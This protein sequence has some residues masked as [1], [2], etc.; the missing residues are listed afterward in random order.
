MARQDPVFTALNRGEVSTQLLGRTDIEHLRLAAQIQENWQPRVLG[1]MSLRPGSAM[2]GQPRAEPAKLVPFVAQFDDTAVIELTD[3]VM[4]VWVND[5]VVTRNSVA[6]V[7]PGFGSWTVARQTGTAQYAIGDSGL[8]IWGLNA[9]ASCAIR[10]AVSVGPDDIGREHGV[11]V[12]VANGPIIFRIGSSA[13]ADDLFPSETLDTGI[14]SLAFTPASG[15]VYVEL[16]SAIAPEAYST[17]RKSQP[18]G[19]YQVTVWSVAIESAGPMQLLTPWT[20]A[21]IQAPCKLRFASSAD[22]IFVAAPGTPQNQIVRYGVTSWSIVRYRPVKG[23]M[24]AT[25]GDKSIV[26]TIPPTSDGHTPVGNTVLDA[27]QPFFTPDDVGTLF[28]LYHWRQDFTQ[29]ITSGDTWTDAIRVSGVSVVSEIS[30]GSV[31]DVPTIDR[32]FGIVSTGTWSGTLMLQRSFDGYS[33]GFNDYKPFT[34]NIPSQ[35]VTDSLNNVIVYYRLGF[36]ADGFTSGSAT[37]TISYPGGGGEGIVHVTGY[38]SPTQVNVEILVPPSA[39][40][41]AFDWRQSQWSPKQGYPSAVAIHEGRLWW[42]GADRWWGSTSDDYSNFD[43]DQIGDSAYIDIAVGQGPI[44]DINW[45]LSIDNLLGGGDTQIIVARSDAIQTPLTPTNF[46]LRF[47]TTQ[48]TAKIQ[49]VKIDNRAI[50]VNQSGRR[51]FLASYDLYTYNYKAVELTNLNPDIGGWAGGGFVAMAV[52]RNPDTIVH[53]VRADGQMVCLLYD[54]DDDVKAFWRKTTAGSYKDVILL[55]GNIEDQVYAL[56]ARANGTFIE[57]FAR[58][59]EC[60]GDAVCKLVD[61]HSV[62]LGAA[63]T[64]ISAPWLAGRQIAVWADGI[65]AGPIQLDGSGHGTL[66]TAAS[67]IT[68]GLPYKAEFLSTK[69]AYGAQMGTAL[70]EIKRADHIGLVLQNTHCRGVRY[71]AFPLNPVRNGGT[72][73][74]DSAAPIDDMPMVEKGLEVPPDTIWAHYDNIR[75]EWPGDSDTDA[76]IYLEAASPRPATVMAVTF[77]METVG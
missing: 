76:R 20:A 42:A 55:P 5:A 44:A 68:F 43:F 22:V 58:L 67:H 19:L 7:I 65:D 39:Y 6:T 45:L 41:S 66:A 72:D 75:M 60:F 36:H 35:A 21:M 38:V 1:P 17:V 52:Q 9:G 63:T 23:P 74:W 27:S 28:R 3:S 32:V 62:Y 70:N 30:G 48:G 37:C 54:V 12:N 71:G 57:K 61:C 73:F 77:S 46:N 8:G 31:V 56:V 29:T 13:G 50:F 16:A 49:G 18:Q 11:S 40:G 2:I 53:L 33:T 51:I 15:T 24:V 47:S 69:L 34:S 64:S 59:D 25:P 10:T 14:Y 26:L 4:R